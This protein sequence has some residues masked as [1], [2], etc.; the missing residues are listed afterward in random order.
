[1]YNKINQDEFKSYFFNNG[2]Y[3]FDNFL[4]FDDL[5]FLKDNFDIN[6]KK[7]QKKSKINFGFFNTLSDIKNFNFERIKKRK[8]LKKIFSK[9]ELHKIAKLALNSK[10]NEYHADYYFSS[11][12][13]NNMVI[14]WHTD[15]AYSGKK[16]ITN[17]VNPDKAAIK[18]FFYLTDV[19]SENGCLGYIPGS[20]K[21]S[22]ILKKLILE[23]KISYS[24]YWS[25]YDYRNL[26]CKQEIKEKIIKYIDKN[27]IQN[28]LKN[29]NFILTDKDIKN[30]DIH[31][32]AGSLLIFDES[33]V[34]RA[35]A[36]KKFERKCIRFFFKK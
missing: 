2:Y 20:H 1:M 4:D 32:K 8:I 25:L 17:F 27:K 12:D 22:Y 23:N 28:F 5:N 11:V 30:Y 33:G 16:I 26:I 29:S 21:I 7:E 15:Q 10:I 6:K 9:Y 35:S 34:H 13:P 24:P 3:L 14:P 31:A 18:F 19:D 36:I